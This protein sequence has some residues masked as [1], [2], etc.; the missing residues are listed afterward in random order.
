[1]TGK[2]SALIMRSRGTVGVSC[3]KQT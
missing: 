3:H 2:I 1:L